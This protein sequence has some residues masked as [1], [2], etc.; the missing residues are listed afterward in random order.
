MVKRA[1]ILAVGL[2]AAMCAGCASR[3]PK[4]ASTRP[5][6]PPVIDSRRGGGSFPLETKLPITGVADLVG[7]LDAGYLKRMTPPGGSPGGSHGGSQN[8][9]ATSVVTGHGPRAWLKELRINVSNWQVNPEYKPTELLPDAAEENT[10]YVDHLLYTAEP[11]KYDSGS[12][13]VRLEADKAEFQILKDKKGTRGFVLSGARRGSLHI[14]APMSEFESATFGAAKK[15]ADSGG[16]GTEDIHGVLTSTD[17]REVK[18]VL[19]VK[20]SWLLL[21]LELKITGKVTVDDEMC[22]N[23]SEMGCDG[24]GPAGVIIAPF[25]D[26]EMKKIDGRRSPLMVFRDGKTHATDFQIHV[27]KNFD[28]LIKFGQ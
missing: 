24:D 15:G 13:N 6:G 1:L 18:G 23:F 3:K 20:G 19:T 21:P 25:V 10:V 17:P 5:L 12:L 27:D 9:S 28:L 14:Y 26:R 7:A 16:V 2:A 11:L 8:G 4:P 22:A